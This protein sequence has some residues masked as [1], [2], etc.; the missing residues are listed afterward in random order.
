MA[1][2]LAVEI[3]AKLVIDHNYIDEYGVNSTNGDGDDVFIAEDHP[4]VLLVP[5]DDDKDYDITY[6]VWCDAMHCVKQTFD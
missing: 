5:T 6:L 2:E 3:E 1:Q 4:S